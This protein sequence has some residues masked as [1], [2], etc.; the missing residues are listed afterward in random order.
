MQILHTIKRARTSVILLSVA[1]TA[2]VVFLPTYDQFILPKIVWVKVLTEVLAILTVA[3]M[4]AGGDFRLRIHPLNLVLFLFVA[5][6]AVSWFWAE[7]R[8]LAADN[9]RWWVMLF[10]W[11][12]LF[13][14]WLGRERHRLMLCAGAL[15]LSALALAL[16]ILLQD[17]GVAFYQTWVGDLM[18]LPDALRD[19]LRGLLDR[20]TGAGVAVA[21]LPDWRGWL[22]AGMGNTNHIA[23]YLALL[24]PM[25][26]MQYLLARGKWR[27]ILTLAALTAACAALIACY[28]VGSNAGLILAGLAMAAL[29]IAYE[30]REFWRQRV[31]RLGVLVVLLAAITAF[32]VLPH[33]LNPHP[34]G[35]F[36]QAFSSERWHEG[37]PTRV[38]IWLTSLEV[39]RNHP[40]LGI[41]AGN[42]TYGYAATLSPRVLNRP[43]LA[44]YAGLYTNAAHNEPLQAW[45]E[46]GVV[47]MLLLLLL[48]AVFIRSVTKQLGHETS[49]SERRLR[50][51]LLAMM[52]AF[53]AH[54]LM[55]FTLQLPAS[56]LLFVGL[57]AVATSF[58]RHEDEFALTVRSSYPGLEID[59]ETTGMRRIESVGFGLGP[60][61]V[62]RRIIGIG[63]L[64]VGAW[65][66][67]NSI[68]TLAADVYFNRAKAA[69]QWAPPALTEGF[70]RRALALNPNHHTARKLLGTV[71]LQTRRYAEAREAFE[72]ASE[73]ETVYDFYKEL[74][75]ACWESGDREAAG[76]YWA[77]Y[78]GRC[79]QM[80][81][82]DAQF[83]AFF[84]KEFPQ[85]AANLAAPAQR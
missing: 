3:R 5:W 17:F 49:D 76:R 41:G 46:T 28:S 57:I 8:S 70:A 66:I 13:Q 42:F 37:W 14:D 78:F 81:E 20:L 55:N 61:Q 18:S 82:R 58:R 56:S 75:W 67:A 34:G 6:K 4:T 33:P 35:I 80:R 79:P 32:Y 26:A 47:G 71:L 7:S 21:K 27:E 29:L 72:K 22:W 85:E 48:W 69:I 2:L 16:W 50:T 10:V 31:L 12:L 45:V 36:R 74:G 84:L 59:I 25:I 30:S 65:A 77:I 52:V 19:P 9:I 83:F 68:P 53:I 40:W 62:W 51:I 11:S 43:D 39:V 38:A 44:P 1:A 73:R 23:D 63:A 60:S 54:S 15:T 64:A 24:Y